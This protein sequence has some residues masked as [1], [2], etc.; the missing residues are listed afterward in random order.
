MRL[1]V[2]P[3]RKP[4]ANLALAIALA[5][6]TAVA[7]VGVAEPAHAQKKKKKK[8]G[9]DAAY[10]SEF[11]AAYNPLNEAVTA[12]TADVPAIRGQ[13]DALLAMATSP[14]EKLASGNLAYQ[15]GANSQDRGLQLAGMEMMLASGKLSIE[16]QPQYNFVAYQLAN[17]LNDQ[18]K[19][20]QYLQQA[21]NLNYTTDEISNDLLQA[22]MAESYFREDRFKEG[23]DYLSSAISA[24]EATGSAAPE[25]WYRRG[26]Q[27]GYSNEIVPEVYDFVVGWVEH[28]PSETN[29][30][31]A[32]NIARNLNTYKSG[33]MLDLMRLAF[34]IDTM[35]NK[36][37]YIEYVEAADARRLPKEVADV[38]EHGYA[39]GRASKDDIYLA[40]SLSTAKGRIAADRSELP[41]L[42][43]D[44]RAASAGLRTVVA[45]GDA[46]LSYSQFAKAEEFYSK[47]LG[48]PGVDTHEV[49]TRLGIAQAKQG[50]NAAAA[51]TFA[52]V[53]GSRKPIAMLWAAHVA[54]AA[55]DTTT[56]APAPAATAAP[57]PTTGG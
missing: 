7:A 29:W 3:R 52:S 20:R 36:Q 46:F 39:N 16:N 28:Y 41:A 55:A 45:A 30:R 54:Q 4:G 6:G 9:E 49:T 25:E 48:M 18:E 32:V 13:I 47:A 15:A 21:I 34:K 22:Q 44:A 57:E 24:R 38:I 1:N 19:A 53:E 14:D 40:D 2:L 51:A 8:K 27:V 31:D 56:A 43:R 35:N 26:L 17:A 50:K 5:C 33:E 37:D 11:I 10:S 12:G 23:L 42:E